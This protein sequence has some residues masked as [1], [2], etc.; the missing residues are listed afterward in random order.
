MVQ[1][2][3]AAVEFEPTVATAGDDACGTGF[4]EERKEKKTLLELV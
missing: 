2:L 3:S 4:G 1:I